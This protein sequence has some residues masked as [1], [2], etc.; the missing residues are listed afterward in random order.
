MHA[1]FV[2]EARPGAAL[3]RMAL[4]MVAALFIQGASVA[5]AQPEAEGGSK[6]QAPAA[7]A[8]ATAAQPLDE[9]QPPEVSPTPSASA[10][11]P[12]ASTPP[13][14]P[15]PRFKG[16]GLGPYVPP[17]KPAGSIKSIHGA[18]RAPDLTGTAIRTI[19]ARG[20]LADGDRSLGGGA[21]LYARGLGLLSHEWLSFRY[22]DYIELGADSEGLLYRLDGQLAGGPQWRYLDDH[23]MFARIGARAQVARM[24]ALYTA[25]VRAPELQL[26]HHSKGDELQ[27]DLAAHGSYVPLGHV[28]PNGPKYSVAGAWATG[29]Y[30][31]FGWQRLRVD[32]EWTRMWTDTSRTDELT[33]N[34]CALW[35][36]V[37]VC[38]D[39]R[40]FNGK[41]TRMPLRAHQ[42][43]FIGLAVLLGQIEWI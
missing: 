43:V 14:P 38:A 34:V 2:V 3:I 11:T 6:A 33:G 23:S 10:S 29:A 22:M 20:Y 12:S 21:S 27:L 26:G 32:A 36:A 4:P 31:S 9:A 40:L 30:L 5:R 25:A 13:E 1:R 41:D 24:A 17:Q 39:A 37:A 7:P 28:I 35:A 16:P 42:S 8:P 19:G 15:A 18:R